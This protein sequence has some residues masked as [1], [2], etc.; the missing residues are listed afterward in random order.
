MNVKTLAK[1]AAQMDELAELFT[2][3]G[4]TFR[5]AGEAGA[6]SGGDAPAGKKVRGAKPAKAKPADDDTVTEEQV[7]AKLME[8]ADAK[9]AATMKKALESVGAGK[10]S[11]V[12]EEQYQ[13]LM[14]KADELMAEEDK[15]AKA[16][17]GKAKPEVDMDSLTVKFKKLVDEDKAAAKKVLKANGITKLS[18]V[19]Q[20]DDE[21]MQALSDA[22]DAAL[23]G[24]DDDLVG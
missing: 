20:E 3:I 11:D 24:G 5:D 21:A 1:L 4:G 13:E 2:A 6:D 16:K 7:K 12:D 14:D 18:E 15:P 19:D 23:E 22:V 17:K 10:L 8:L 9:G